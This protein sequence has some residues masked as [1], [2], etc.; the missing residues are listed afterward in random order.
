MF[1]ADRDAD[2]SVNAVTLRNIPPAG[3]IANGGI[4]SNA[5]GCMRVVWEIP[6][7]RGTVVEHLLLTFTSERE[8]ERQRGGSR[9][10][11]W[12]QEIR[13]GVLGSLKVP[14]G[15]RAGS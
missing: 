15:P 2:Q 4:S 5:R 12:E 10:L 1:I 14:S 8:R 13:R 6:L 3:M 7:Y 11:C 9:I